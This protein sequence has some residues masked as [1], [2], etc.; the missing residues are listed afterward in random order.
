MEALQSLQVCANVLAH[1]SV[2]TAAGFDSADAWSGEGGVAGQ[3]F[4]VFA[5][6][7][8]ASQIVLGRGGEGMELYRVKMSLVT[9]AM[10]Y[11]S[12]SFRHNASI[13]AVLPDPT[14]LANGVKGSR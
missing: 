3:E 9:A 11:S 14:G 7:G 6:E 10:L 4:G 12:R 1:S 5:K 13:K 8:W 2:R